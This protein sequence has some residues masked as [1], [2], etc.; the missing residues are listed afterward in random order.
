MKKFL[1]AALLLATAGSPSFADDL[2]EKAMKDNPG[3]TGGG[4]TANPTQKP[5]SGSLSEKAMKAPVVSGAGTTATPTIKPDSGS[6]SEKAMQD[7]PGV[8]K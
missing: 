4:T 8:S 7:H 5:D 2:S 3:V 6:L 1:F